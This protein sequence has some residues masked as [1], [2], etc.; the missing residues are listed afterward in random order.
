MCNGQDCQ[1]QVPLTWQQFY[2]GRIATEL[3]LHVPALIYYCSDTCMANAKPIPCRCGADWEHV[4][5]YNDAGMAELAWLM[6]MR[7]LQ[8]V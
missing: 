3:G 8:P 4:C 7:K 2:N 6:H 1:R 5:K